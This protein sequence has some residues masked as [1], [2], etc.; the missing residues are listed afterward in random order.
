MPENQGKRLQLLLIFYRGT[1]TINVGI[2]LLFAVMGF[3]EIGPAY[4]FKMFAISFVTAGPVICILYK[5]LTGRD[6]YYFYYNN[7]VSKLWLISRFM[8]VNI[9]IASLI[10]IVSLL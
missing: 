7:A 6:Q 8:M 9:F 2:S 10:F 1:I 5:E 4:F 3:F